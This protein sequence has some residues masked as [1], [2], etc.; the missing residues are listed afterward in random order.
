[1]ADGDESEEGHEKDAEEDPGDYLD[2]QFSRY[3]IISVF[4]GLSAGKIVEK[5]VAIAAPTAPAKLAGW[6]IAF[7]L[8]ISVAWYWPLFERRYA[9]YLP[10]MTPGGD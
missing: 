3:G 5:I 10:W 9:E 4:I 2:R 6:S 7:P 1:M 8:A